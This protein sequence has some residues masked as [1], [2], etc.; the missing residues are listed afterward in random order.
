[1]AATSAGSRPLTSQCLRSLKRRRVM[2]IGRGA[3]VHAA[4][5]DA[6]ID[7][8]G[9]QY[10]VLG[11]EAQRSHLAAGSDDDADVDDRAEPDG[12]IGLETDGCRLE[13][14]PFDRVAGQV[15]FTAD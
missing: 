6:G 9:L 2:P 3:V 11:D 4:R 5:R 12:D 13:D 14:A 15:N 7:A 10:R 1:M 8:T